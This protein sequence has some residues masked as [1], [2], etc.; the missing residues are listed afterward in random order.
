MS[1]P[2]WAKNIIFLLVYMISGLILALIIEGLL[3]GADLLPLN[4]SIENA[5]S[6]IRTPILTTLMVKF[7]TIANPFLF[8][9]IAVALAVFLI[10]KNDT[11]EA[12]LFLVAFVVTIISLTMLKNFLQI[13]RPATGV[14]QVSGWSFPSGHTTLATAFFFLLSYIFVDKVRTAERKWLLIGICFLGTFLVALSRLYLGAHWAL[15]V[16]AGISLGLMSV[17]FT[18]LIFNLIFGESRSLRRRINL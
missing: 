7:T 12:A 2:I 15:D 1:M 16:M 18:V 17:S 6:A 11:Y 14:Y 9:S 8:A 13:T 10:I 4:T 3:S 5:M